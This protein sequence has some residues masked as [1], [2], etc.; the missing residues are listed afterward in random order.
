M[1]MDLSRHR[2]LE[3]RSREVWIRRVLLIILAVLPVLGLIDAFGQSPGSTTASSS[4]VTLNVQSPTRL[5]GG[6]IY[7]TRVKITP[8]QDIN[9]AILVFDPN[10]LEG[11]TLNTVEPTPTSQGSEHGRLAL[12]LGPIKAGEEWTEYL[13]FQVNPTTVGA[14]NGNVALYDGPR[15]LL[16]LTRAATAFP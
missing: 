7:Q 14:H 9:H 1:T 15:R 4:V 12:F 6:L 16:S 10:W 13:E 8:R 11:Q 3:G 2:D 5:R